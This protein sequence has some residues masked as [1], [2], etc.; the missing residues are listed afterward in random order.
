MKSPQTPDVLLNTVE[1]TLS[2]LVA[3]GARLCVGLSGGV[4]S[5]VLLNVLHRLAPRH[6]WQL[7]AIHVN[8]Q[9]SAHAGEWAKRCRRWCRELGVTLRVVK[10]DVA[11]GN[12][13]EAA[14]RAARNEAFRAQP[15]EHVVMAQHLDDQAETVL[16]QLLR[17]TGV[18]GLA[19]MPVIRNDT[20][21]PGLRLLRPLLSITRREIETYAA[22]HKLSWVE[23]ESNANTHFLRNF[24]RVEIMPR[25]ETRAPDYRKTLSRTAGHMAEAAHLLD[26]LAEMDCAGAVVDGTLPVS[27]LCDLPAARARNLLRYFLARHRVSMP[28]TRRLEEALRQ[29][30]TAKQDARVSIALGGHTLRR[31][32][33]RLHVVL[34]QQRPVL[35]NVALRWHLQP[36]LEVPEL[37]AVLEMRRKRGAG[38]DLEKLLAQ[39]VVLRLRRGGEKLRIDGARPRRHLKALFQQQGVPPWRRDRLPCLWSGE[40]LVWVAGLGVDSA[41][42][43]RPGAAGV[44]PRWVERDGSLAA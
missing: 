21:R 30:V 29:V 4:D 19:A 6:A 12:S 25:L 7:S 35:N 33:G 5:V 44:V 13:I 24:L 43:A 23:D 16:L 42:Q 9:L 20:E 11:R 17:G 41:F 14:A 28:D 40:H 36:R 34:V 18:K 38:I 10:V 3:N 8:H 2:A 15:A 22:A 31:F 32:S 26:V 39:P 27:V 1:R 37:Q